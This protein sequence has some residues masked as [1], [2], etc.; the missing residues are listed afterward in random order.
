VTTWQV[1]A[2]SITRIDEPGFSLTVPQDEATAAVLLEEASW[3]VPDHVTRDGALR[4][5]S[6]AVVIRAPDALVVVDPWLAF[7]G[8]DRTAPEAVQRVD[9]LLDLLD[10]AGV[11]R[12]EVDVVVNSHL[13]GVGANLCSGPDGVDAPSF[14]NAQYLLGE[15]ELDELQAGTHPDAAAMRVLIDQGRIAAVAEDV[16]LTDQITLGIAPGHRAG[17]LAVH[18][19]SEGESALVAGHLFL[20]PAQILDP[21]PRPTLDDQPERAAAARRFVLAQCAE[22]G[23]LLVCPLFA[24]PGG[25][26]IVAHG[27]TWRLAS[28]RPVPVGSA[29]FRS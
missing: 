25:G 19:R 14:P 7:D 8:P 23:T 5:G 3:L 18:I 22:E 4:M 9:R 27:D 13:H 11:R 16:T 20:H 10:R 15:P 28:E 21:G 1:G 26:W 29:P 6:C 12:A 2:V 24:A 17:H